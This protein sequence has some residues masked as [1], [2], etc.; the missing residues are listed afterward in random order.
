[1]KQKMRI[2]YTIS[3][4]VLNLIQIQSLDLSENLL[5]DYP[6]LK[7]F[8]ALNLQYTKKKTIKMYSLVIFFFTG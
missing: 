2:R 4:S 5:I 3:I 6:N 1:M 8:R 7:D